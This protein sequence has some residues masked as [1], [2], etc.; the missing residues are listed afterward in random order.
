MVPCCPSPATKSACV[1]NVT[2]QIRAEAAQ[3]Q[4]KYEVYDANAASLC[5]AQYRAQSGS[6]VLKDEADLA[7]DFG[8]CQA[9]WRAPARSPGWDCETTEQCARV[10]G[11]ITACAPNGRCSAFVKVGEGAACDATHLCTAGLSCIAGACAKPVALGGACTP[12]EDPTHPSRCAEG[13]ACNAMSRRCEPL[14]EVGQPCAEFQ[15]AAHAFC[16]ASTCLWRGGVGDAC[17]SGE[18][19]DS[20]VCGGAK[21]CVEKSGPGSG[22]ITSATCDSGTC[23]EGVCTGSFDSVGSFYGCS[24]TL[25]R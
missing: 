3:A 22:C 17:I 15:C 24:A 1:A 10:P 8:P 25:G 2:A 4:Q 20:G 23:L 9:I 16:Y 21:G 7:L 14:P 12:T 19:C 13:T 6:C 11:T 5:R 18:E